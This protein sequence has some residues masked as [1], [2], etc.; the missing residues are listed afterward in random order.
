VPCLCLYNRVLH[1]KRKIKHVTD[2]IS[3]VRKDWVKKGGAY[4]VDVLK[5]MI[6][7]NLF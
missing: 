2:F 3:F 7:H 1:V 6:L 5:V 4:S